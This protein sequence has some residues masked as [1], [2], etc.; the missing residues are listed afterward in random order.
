MG[1]LLKTVHD[2]KD[3]LRFSTDWMVNMITACQD[4]L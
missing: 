3:G 1:H 2:D 4:Y